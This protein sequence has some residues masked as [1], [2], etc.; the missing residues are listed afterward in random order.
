MYGQQ[1]FHM[2]SFKSKNLPCGT[3][4][5]DKLFFEPPYKLNIK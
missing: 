5:L 2:N 1:K 4:Y 3:F